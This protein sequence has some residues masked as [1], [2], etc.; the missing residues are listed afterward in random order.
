MN[1]HQ[2]FKLLQRP[3][4]L[5]RRGPDVGQ[6]P[7]GGAYGW[8]LPLCALE[9]CHFS[10]GAVLWGGGFEGGEGLLSG[11]SARPSEWPE[12]AAPLAPYSLWEREST[13]PGLPT[14]TLPIA[15]GQSWLKVEILG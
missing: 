9:A 5:S 12:S 7:A 14:P 4:H 3:K 2:L 15:P 8:G 1:E 11:A 13:G 6:P 10:E